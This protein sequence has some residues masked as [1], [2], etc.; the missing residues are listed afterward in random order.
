M[1]SVCRE[2]NV[3]REKCKNYEKKRNFEKKM[4]AKVSHNFAFRKNIFVKILKLSFHINFWIF[5]VPNFFAKKRKFLH[6]SRANEMR[7]NAKIFGKRFFLFPSFVTLNEKRN[8]WEL[9]S[10]THKYIS[11]NVK[12]QIVKN[13]CFCIFT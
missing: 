6:F 2:R 4:C 12:I 11:L 5:L 7:K 3:S 8:I 10:T 9:Q 13:V 1:S